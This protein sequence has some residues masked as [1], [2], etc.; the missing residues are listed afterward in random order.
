MAK[1][2]PIRSPNAIDQ[3]VFVIGLSKNIG[4]DNVDAIKGLKD[5][6]ASEFDEFN[7]IHMMGI[8][9]SPDGLNKPDKQ[10]VG[11]E[12]KTETKE[13]EHLLV[14]KR[15]DWLLRISEN[16]I[17]INC[18]NYAGWGQ[19]V[20][21]VGHLL[22]ILFESLTTTLEGVSI[23]EITFQVNDMFIVSDADEGIDYSQ[24]FNRSKYLNE[25]IWGAGVLWHLHSG[26][27][28]SDDRAGNVLSVLNISTRTEVTIPDK[29][30]V[31]V[32]HLQKSTVDNGLS[33]EI[34]KTEIEGLFGVLHEKNKI[35]VSDL[36]SDDI[37]GRIGL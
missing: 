17:Q 37:K 2:D 3:A 6:L 16:S 12:C 15:P 28:E 31:L 30:I 35:L 13:Q 23:I 18:L 21:H 34:N 4:K 26:W 5:R 1:F 14:A 9:L 11:V 25:N 36:F 20:G 24:L 19:A 27:F 10:V 29:H 22:E 7:D 8:E 33:I 32:E